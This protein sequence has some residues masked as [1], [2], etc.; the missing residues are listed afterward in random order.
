MVASGRGVDGSLISH[1]FLRFVCSFVAFT[2]LQTEMPDFSSDVGNSLVPFV[3]FHS[4]ASQVLF[5][6]QKLEHPYLEMP[7]DFSN[8]R[9][10]CS[11]CTAST[12]MSDDTL[13]HFC[14]HVSVV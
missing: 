6:G 2:E 13:L 8:V 11:H 12:Y 1:I 5:P 4:Y 10:V 3:D 14:M 9:C 7:T